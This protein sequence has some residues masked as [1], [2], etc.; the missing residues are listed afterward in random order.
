MTHEKRPSGPWK[1]LDEHEIPWNV[2]RKARIEHPEI[3]KIGSSGHA[4]M[5]TEG[6]PVVYRIAIVTK[7]GQRKMF[8]VENAS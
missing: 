7:G 4:G 5:R 3:A 6:S 1:K 2:R 8:E